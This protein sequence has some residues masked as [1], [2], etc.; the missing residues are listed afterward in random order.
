MVQ[1]ALEKQRHLS[2]AALHQT[3]GVGDGVAP[4]GGVSDGCRVRHLEHHTSV[5]G[6]HTH[7]QTHTLI[8]SHVTV[9]VIIWVTMLGHPVD[10]RSLE[11]ERKFL[12][13]RHTDDVDVINHAGCL[14]TH[15]HTHRVTLHAY[16][17]FW[18]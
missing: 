12:R 17:R 2:L 18:N 4:H 16:E 13:H 9:A 10:W 11:E 7:T 3:D 1:E 5:Y 15:A 6:L 8:N 14:H